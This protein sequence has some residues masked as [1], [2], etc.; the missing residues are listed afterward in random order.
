MLAHKE[1]PMFRKALWPV[2]LAGGLLCA[3]TSGAVS[4]TI[5]TKSAKAVLDAIRNP[6]LT[7]DAALA[8][9]RLPGNQGVIRELVGFRIAATPEAFANALYASAHGQK[10]GNAVEEDFF[11]DTVEPKAEQL[12]ALIGQIEAHPQDF[13]E[14][15]EKRIDMFAPPNARVPLHGYVVAGGDGGGY[16]FGGT[17]F[18]LNIGIVDELVV[19]RAATTHELYHAVQGAFDAAHKDPDAPSKAGSPRQLACEQTDRLF[20]N[21][22]REGS[23]LYVEDI[24]LIATAQSRSGLR[25]KDDL[26][27]GLKHIGTSVNLLEMSVAS[28][29]A[30][31]PVPYEDVYGVGF[32]GHA[33]L[34][35]IGYVMAKAIVEADGPQGLATFLTRPPYEFALR[36]TALPK[37]ALD[38]DHPKLGPNTIDALARLKAGCTPP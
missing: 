37:Y 24:S 14:A 20:R 9:A 11:F 25:I 21:V 36:Y 6:A 12:Q 17:D 19:A 29:N 5:D 32:Y 13:K 28:L 23:A 3:G 34:Y 1:T 31:T 26:A 15:I 35:N 33:I 27:D 22:Y 16:A 8:I 2:A 10:A 38:T 30:A 18:Y 4:V 7:H